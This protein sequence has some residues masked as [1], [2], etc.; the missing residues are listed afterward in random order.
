MASLAETPD[1]FD[2]ARSLGV[3][4]SPSTPTIGAEIGGLDLEGYPE[5]LR[6]EGVEGVQV[7]VSEEVV[8]R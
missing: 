4:I 6:I 5:I 3:S 7:A 8:T 1:L 2:T